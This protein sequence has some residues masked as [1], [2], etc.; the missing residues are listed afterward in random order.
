[1]RQKLLIEQED[2]RQELAKTDGLVNDWMDITA[3]IFNFACKAQKKWENG[4]VEEKKRIILHAIG[5]SLVLKNKQLS[6]T[7]RS[8]FLVVQEAKS[9]GST[10]EGSVHGVGVGPTWYGFT[11]RCINRSATHG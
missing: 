5:S 8:M 6:I 10:I 7:P 9:L 1:M 2:L 4:T 3:R 11:V